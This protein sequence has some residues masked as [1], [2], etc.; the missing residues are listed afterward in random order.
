MN[1]EQ[2]LWFDEKKSEHELAHWY[3]VVKYRADIQN[4]FKWLESRRLHLFG[5]KNN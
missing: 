3:D 1:K 4:T 2:V 5:E